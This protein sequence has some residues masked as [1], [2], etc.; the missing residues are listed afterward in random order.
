MLNAVLRSVVFNEKNIVSLLTSSTSEINQM[1]CRIF[2]DC[3]Q[4]LFSYAILMK[5]SRVLTLS[6]TVEKCLCIRFVCP[7]VCLSVR[8]LTLINILQMSWNWYML[9]ISDIAW[10]ALKMV[11]IRL[12]VCLKRHTNFFRYIKAYGGKIFQEHFN[13]FRLL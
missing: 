1:R 2:Q 11:Y 13:V 8:A 5:Y 9:F 6:N 7:S 3:S 12:T 4:T 10:T